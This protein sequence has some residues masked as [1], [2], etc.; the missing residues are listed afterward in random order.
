M[1]GSAGGTPRGSAWTGIAIAVVRVILPRLL[2]KERPGLRRLRSP[3]PWPTTSPRHLLS[4]PEETSIHQHFPYPLICRAA[5]SMKSK[6]NVFGDMLNIF[7]GRHFPSGHVTRIWPA[8]VIQSNK[9][10]RFEWFLSPTLLRFIISAQKL[11]KSRENL[12]K[13]RFV[14]LE[15]DN[16]LFENMPC[17]SKPHWIRLDRPKTAS[18]HWRI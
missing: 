13:N 17:H 16:I 12:K 1:G 4:L 8:F 9:S 11:W 15:T 18:F 2:Q 14:Q 6:Q 10:T 5:S 7:G 3:S